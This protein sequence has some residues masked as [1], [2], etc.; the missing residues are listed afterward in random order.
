MRE[1]KIN[2]RHPNSHCLSTAFSSF[3]FSPLLILSLTLQVHTK[4][5]KEKKNFVPCLTDKEPEVQRI[6]MECPISCKKCLLELELTF[7]L[8]DQSLNK[9]KEPSS[10]TSLKISN[11]KQSQWWWWNSSWA[12]SNPKRWYYETAAL[13]CQQIWKTQQW[14]RN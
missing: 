6:E 9:Q 3:F 10:F 13:I 12:I 14:P 2:C 7:S 4:E 11:Y 5:R 1:V 8:L